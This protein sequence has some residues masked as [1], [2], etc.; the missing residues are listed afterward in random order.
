V[1]NWRGE[2][3]R[4]RATQEA[5]ARLSQQCTFNPQL[6]TKRRGRP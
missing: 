6:A 2:L 1:Y 4:V 5:E 3:A